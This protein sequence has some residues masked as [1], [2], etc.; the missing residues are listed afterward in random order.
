MA[1]IMAGLMM[2][3]AEAVTLWGLPGPPGS[4]SLVLLLPPWSTREAVIPLEKGSKRLLFARLQNV[5][6][7]CA[8]PQP[9]HI[10]LS[11]AV[12]LD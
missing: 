2:M 8:I 4:E 3:V 7:G 9:H 12:G 11:S 1:C 5:D 6:K 10:E